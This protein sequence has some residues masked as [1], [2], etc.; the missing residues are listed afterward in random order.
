MEDEKL[1]YQIGTNIA[2]FRKRQGLTQ[3]GLAEKINYSDKA[4]SKWER[5]ESVPDV[6]TLVALAREFG[7]SVD[8]LLSDPDALP[9]QTGRVQ[10]A[11]D[12]VVQKTLKRKA[13]K[14][15][16]T[17]L[18]SLLVWFVALLLY[19]IL[20]SIGISKS[21]LAFFYAIPADAIVVLCL[22]S[23][24]RDYRSNQLLISVII[25]GALASIYV[26][27][28]VIL[29]LNVWRILLLGIPGQLAI[30]LWF[31]MFRTVPPTEEENG[32]ETTQKADP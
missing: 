22:R 10:Q 29:R 12:H 27:L 21:W 18:S 26:T 31:R 14:R 30:W 9:E 1:K 4:I 32:Q 17:N 2:L 24:W 7:V 28:L 20:S 5:G 3:A 25:W 15:I 19:V 6:V 11:M 8:D 16:I 23:A 13:D